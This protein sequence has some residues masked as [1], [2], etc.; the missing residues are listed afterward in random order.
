M[1]SQPA[2]QGPSNSYLKQKIQS[3][4]TGI[5]IESLSFNF[6]G[7]Q[8]SLEPAI[9]H[10]GKYASPTQRIWARAGIGDF[11]DWTGH[12]R[13]LQVWL[14]KK[15]AFEA[16]IIRGTGGSGKTR[17]G[18]ELCRYAGQSQSWTAGFLPSVSDPGA[19]VSSQRDSSHLLVVIDYAETRKSQL[20]ELLPTLEVQSSI[21]SKVRVLLLVRDAPEGK[22][23]LRGFM[24]GMSA[25]YN[26]II[27]DMD[28]DLLDTTS[29]APE[30]RLE[31]FTRAAQSLVNDESPSGD[32]DRTQL[33]S[34]RPP[35]LSSPVFSLPLLVLIA[36]YLVVHDEKAAA[37]SKGELLD[38]LLEHEHHYWEAHKEALNPPL[39]PQLRECVVALATLACA[40]NEDEARNLL[41]L[42]EDFKGDAAAER[43]GDIAA[44]VKELYL[45]P[46]YWN[47]MELDLLSEHLVAKHFSGQHDILRGVLDRSDIRLLRRPLLVLSRA[48]DS[49]PAL[50]N[51]C[52]E[53]FST[54]LGRIV[55]L[56]LEQSFGV[57]S[58]DE[59]SN[60]GILGDI[61]GIAFAKVPLTVDPTELWSVVR[62]LDSTKYPWVCSLRFALTLQLYKL[63]ALSFSTAP[64]PFAEEYCSASIALVNELKQANKD[65]DALA[66]EDSALE[67]LR[68]LAERE[69]G[70]LCTAYLRL[71][72]SAI[73][74]SRSYRKLPR[75]LELSLAR[76]KYL[77]VLVLDNPVAFIEEYMRYLLEA[78]HFLK[79]CGSQAELRSLMED[80]I[81]LQN[82]LAQNMPDRFSLKFE[83]VRLVMIQ[84]SGNVLKQESRDSL[85]AN[86]KG[87]LTGDSKMLLDEDLVD[88]DLV[89]AEIIGLDESDT[90]DLFGRTIGVSTHLRE[91]STNSNSDIEIDVK[92]ALGLATSIMAEVRESASNIAP[93]IGSK[94][95]KL[96]DEQAL[97][98]VYVSQSLW[99]SLR[100]LKE[101]SSRLYYDKEKLLV[102]EGMVKLAKCLA[103]VDPLEW[104]QIF[105]HIV[106]ECAAIYVSMKK[107]E[108][109]VLLRQEVVEFYRRLAI[110]DV[111][112][113][114]QEYCTC[115]QSMSMF[116]RSID[117][118]KDASTL[119]GELFDFYYDLVALMPG[120]F[121]RH[122]VDA[123]GA[124][125]FEYW[126]EGSR[127]EAS[128]L[129]TE[130]KNLSVTYDELPGFPH[131]F[132]DNLV[133]MLFGT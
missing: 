107:L 28:I 77:S 117:R 14:D 78:W 88:E 18:V 40:S 56:A 23:Q 35:D 53:V 105:E 81:G 90:M 99:P 11:L 30:D 87:K 57:T 83:W 100:L 118:K 75:L 127:G 3:G 60:G 4:A 47:P 64:K 16:R 38:Q 85:H 51:S 37:S 125:A 31:L 29:F 36:A 96:Q 34:L 89:D 45:G 72:E 46:E 13:D 66:L 49:F 25:V 21:G 92:D 10:P 71:L 1:T 97:M 133:F 116:L 121:I 101:T 73:Y 63:V 108:E 114:H 129:A 94:F 120:Q 132:V 124:R 131:E 130:L 2:G 50:R 52:S 62:Q 98:L 8:F 80:A 119:D 68:L 43:R 110:Q 65:S 122:L 102:I 111:A 104:G 32:E 113:Y 79:K 24:H 20:E 19:T 61:M 15:E 103:G 7:K 82:A 84:L 106:S 93:P 48:V 95:P 74:T 59:I 26:R 126:R 41:E 109:A 12:L 17:L 128:R 91:I 70:N 55:S 54:L 39:R 123:L 9:V 67:D 76:V 86:T 44:W 22:L 58:I 69:S 42:L 5:Q 33:N 27:D 115:M 6:R 112:T